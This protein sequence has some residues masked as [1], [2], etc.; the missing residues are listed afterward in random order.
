MPET[1]FD[2]TLQGQKALYD[3]RFKQGYVEGFHDLYERCRLQSLNY[4]FKQLTKSGFQPQ[5][6]FD[7][8]CGQG[9]FLPIYQQ[10]FPDAKITA[11]DISDVALEFAQ[12]RHPAASFISMTDEHIPLPDASFDLV[13]SIEV[14]EHVLDAH[15]TMREIVRLVKP[16]GWIVLTTPCANR[17]SLEWTYN[18]LTGGFKPSLDGYGKFSSEDP[19]HLR[20]LKD[21][22][23]RALFHEAGAKVDTIYHRAHIFTTIMASMPV[24]RR[25]P[26]DLRTQIAYLDWALFKNLPNGAT[27]IA[28]ARV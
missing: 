11:S 26:L 7:Y 25:L 4:V 27:M 5:S 9:K 24:I 8:G 28:I 16:G 21:D 10:F 12:R 20:R 13:T 22:D 23:V 15:A 1:N 3:S 17:Y 19:E 2:K 18:F 14:I 6:M